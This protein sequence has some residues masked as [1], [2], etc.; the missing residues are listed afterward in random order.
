M[1]R[2]VRNPNLDSRDARGKLNAGVKHWG[3]SGE[4][5][6]HIGYRRGPRGGTWYARR[7]ANGAYVLMTL[8]AADDKTDADGDVVLSYRDA[9]TKARAWWQRESRLELGLADQRSGPYTVAAACDDYLEHFR[10]KGAKSEYATKRTIEVHIRPVLGDRDANKLTMQQVRD[11]HR[12]LATAPK[13]VRTKQT[14]EKRATKAIDAKDPDAARSRRATANRVLTV[15][16]AVLNH[17]WRERHISSDE[18]WRTVKPFPKVDA[19]VVRYLTDDEC[20]RLVN[21]CDPDLRA[22]VQGALMTGARYGELARLR[23]SDVN[24]DNGTV[25]IREAKGGKPRHVVLT[26]EGR[27]LFTKLTT[28]RTGTETVFTHD[29]K[30][31]WKASQQTRPLREACE[32]L[33][34]LDAPASAIAADLGFDD[35]AYFTRFFKRMT[36]V[37]PSAFREGRGNSMIALRSTRASCAVSK[38]RA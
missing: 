16:K 36:G 4:L 7:M 12:K 30:T 31:A 1:A 38:T 26:D 28:G 15:L 33:V 20:R 25:A 9:L 21:T 34:H 27:E 29:D 22:L 14:A 8:G 5:G 32:R 10:A 18:A 19:A 35:P 3:Q 11:W 13:M 23:V 6:L 24:L 37:S 17:A 2:T